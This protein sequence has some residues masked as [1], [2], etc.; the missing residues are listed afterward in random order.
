MVGAGPSIGA[1]IPGSAA[2][3][4]WVATNV[5]LTTEPGDP[6][7]L[8]AV[9]DCVD[10]GLVPP[11]ELKR[12]VAEHVA[13]FPLEPTELTTALVNVPS[14]LVITFN[15]DLLIEQTANA[16]DV[17]YERLS[18]SDLKRAHELIVTRDW[19]PDHLV[20]LHLHGHVED[21]DSIVLDGASYREL[22]RDRLFEE[23]VF[24][25]SHYKTLVF[26][27][28]KLDESYLVAELAKQTNAR[29]HILLCPEEQ[30]SELEQGRLALSRRRNYLTIVAYPDHS[31]LVSFPLMLAAAETSVVA[32]PVAAV[33][34][35]PPDLYVPAELRDRAAP[36]D[37]H[38][39]I[40]ATF[41]IPTSVP[42]R[43]PVS[44]DDVA[45]GHRTLLVGA[46]G[47][48]KSE[49]MRQ[50]AHTARPDRPALLIR[51]ADVRLAAGSAEATL[52]AWSQMARSAQADV[53]TS[54]EALAD[55]RY[56]FLLDGVDEVQTGL[57][58]YAARLIAD[59]AAAFPQHAFTVASRPIDALTAFGT[60]VEDDSE[61]T[62]WRILDLQPTAAWRTEYLTRRGVT[63]D[64]LEAAMPVLRDLGELLS[65]PFF[66][67]QA[68]D[69]YQEGRLNGLTDLWDLV[70]E[71][72]DAS[73]EREA[74]QLVLTPVEVREWMRAVALAALLAGR[75]TFSIEEL[76]SFP[77]PSAVVGGTDALVEALVQRLLLTER[78]G[79]FLF[80]HRIVGESLAAE[81]LE[82]LEPGEELLAALVPRRASD[83]SGVRS[84]CLVTI[85][86]L[87]SRNDQWRRAV[88]ERDRLA[89]ARA[90]PATADLDERR[91]AAEL[92]WQTY[93]ERQVWMWDYRVP[94]LADDAEAL[95]RLLRGD[96]LHDLRS[97]VR[98]VID[99]GTAED[100]GNAIRVLA[101]VNPEGFVDDLSRVLGDESREGVVRRQAAIAARDLGLH[102][103][104]D[105]IIAR[106]VNPVDDA[107]A[108]DCTYVALQLA[109]D[110]ELLDVAMR[111]IPGRH[112]RAAA[113]DAVNRR[114]PP[115]ARITFSR[116][117]GAADADRSGYDRR[118]LLDAVEEVVGDQ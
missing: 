61:R 78:E 31:D 101:R 116:A 25:L 6:S 7:D 106:A 102:E 63:F 109:S 92:L 29:G 59:V 14:R 41:G 9:V 62:D 49:L 68:V 105:L 24:D 98:A 39:E 80:L 76:R 4:E 100:Q 91:A 43:E 54:R 20:I 97:E 114:L 66:A 58:E 87:A 30:R 12:L 95:G 44:E 16:A 74:E 47:S 2:L 13:S 113:S 56:H 22:A 70:R 42:P 51:L 99:S 57:Q 83:I 77:L 108:Q 10:E 86:L 84:D 103:L 117:L 67:V 8:F 34:P 45:A 1:G 18:G 81:A 111:L 48:G 50:V 60:G 94:G 23:I 32:G 73:L 110:D 85:G 96:G 26:L 5:P 38:D 17:E 36:F 35:A 93:R 52:L 115:A 55:R 71:L 11:P 19:P 79:T 33:E 118:L 89:G 28:T 90:T 107:E 75:R 64:E 15:Y 104:L 112:A 46:P 21:P 65:V 40:R 37:D 82:L 88:S 72:V 27:G 53:G 69:L 3:A